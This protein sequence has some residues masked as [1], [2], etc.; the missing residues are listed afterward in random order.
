MA[1]NMETRARG[2]KQTNQSRFAR[3]MAPRVPRSTF[4]RSRRLSTTFDAAGKIYP[5]LV[6]EILPGDTIRCQ[7]ASLVRMAT[8]LHPILEDVVV[9]YHWFFTPYRIIWDNALKFFGEQ[10]DLDNPQTFLIPTITSTAASHQVGSVYDYMGLPIVNAGLTHSALPLRAYQ[11][12]WND[13]YRPQELS[14][15]V[16]PAGTG[17]GPD[18]ALFYGILDRYRRHDYFSSALISPQRGADVDVP[19][20]GTAPVQSTG[21]QPTFNAA[22]G[23]NQPLQNQSVAGLSITNFPGSPES[24]TFG[25][26]S[27]LET[28]L[29]AVSVLSV[30]AWR[31][32]VTLQQFL[33]AEARGGSRYAELVDTMFGVNFPDRLYRP[34]YLGGSTTQLTVNQV[35]QTSNTVTGTDAS[36]QGNLAAFAQGGGISRP[37]TKSFVEHGVLLC[38]A[39]VRRA[40]V[41]YQQGL[42]RMWSRQTRYDHFFPMF[43]NL[44]EDAILS[45]E[46]FADG[47]ANDDNVWGY[48]ERWAE[49]KYAH[50]NQVTGKM[51]SAATSSLDTW[52]LADDYSTRPT[53]N[54]DWM[55]EDP[56]IDRVIAVTSEP[57]FLAEHVFSFQHTRCMPVSGVPGLRRF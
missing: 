39:S 14:A 51:R 10:D 40:Q 17:D 3:N 21:L 12:I 54:L 56:P 24:V 49:Y 8:P 53:L 18:N 33:E 29:S 52:H 36:P 27:G 23:A 50:P 38:L 11:R 25:N 37:I 20:G 2:S 31:E 13:W 41:T 19:L 5:V 45:K 57:H 28:D 30:N 46:I 9:D 1:R 43:A 44:G 35:P 6:D 26:E 16:E 7:M 55:K 42:H 32:A 22:S 34:E 48:Q 4:N 15:K 47:S